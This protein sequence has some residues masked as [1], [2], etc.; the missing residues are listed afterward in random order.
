MEMVFNKLNV[1][2]FIAIC[3]ALMSCC[4]PC[5]KDAKIQ[6]ECITKINNTVVTNFEIK[7]KSYVATNSVIDSSNI[8]P[9]KKVNFSSVPIQ[10]ISMFKESAR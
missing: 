1:N 4:Y 9:I 5:K 8:A 2:L 6:S 10:N 7:G 3:F